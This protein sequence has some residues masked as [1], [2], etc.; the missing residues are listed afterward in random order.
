[1]RLAKLTGL[2]I[3]KLEAELKEV[4]AFITELKAILGSRE[5]RMGIL[6]DEMNEVAETFGDARRTEI[7]PDQSDSRWRT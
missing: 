6:K 4:R 3:D 5:K 2:E 7:I 1:M